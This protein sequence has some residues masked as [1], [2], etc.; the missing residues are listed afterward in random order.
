MERKLTAILC[1][2]VYGYSR[3]MG[4]DEEAT[5]RTLSSYRKIVDNFIERHHGRFV[6]SA[7]DSILAE[8]TS[9]V[10]AVN[11]AVNVQ[12]AIKAENSNLS[13][14]R[15]MEFRIGVNSGDVMVE[16]E[17]IYGDGVNVAARLENLAEPGGICISGT[18][19][20]QVRDR[21]DLG[22]EDCGQQSV[23]NI[24][25]PVHIWRVVSAGTPPPARLGLKYWRRGVVSL[26]G[27]AIAVGT[28]VLVQHLSLK[29]PHTSASIPPT[30]RPTLVLPAIPSIAV[31]PFTNLSGDPQQEY[32]SDGITNQL[33]EELSRLPG[34]FVIARNSSFAYKG[35]AI[36][37]RDIGRELGVK[38]VLEGTARKTADQVR[39]GVALVDTTSG[40]ELWTARYDQPSKDVFAVQDEIVRR[41]VTTLG[42]VVKADQL[43]VPHWWGKPT[44]N[45]EAFDDLLRAYQYMNRFT[46]D[47]NA[48]ARNWTEKAI[49]L[50]PKSADA[51]S[52]LAWIYF[53]D[54]GWQWTAD[55]QA[56]LRRSIELAQKALTLDDSHC[57]AL[58]LLANDYVFQGQFDQAVAAG[59]RAVSINPNCSIGYAF[60]AAALNAAGKPGEA[61]RAVEKAMRLDPAGYAFYAGEVGAADILMGRYQ[62]AVPS[63]QRTIAATPNAS[64]AHLELAVAYVELG[65]DRDARAEAAEVMRVSPNY[66]LPRQGTGSAVP[67]L[68]GT[69]RALQRRFDTDLRRAGLK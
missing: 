12:N 50:D 60:L 2:D 45:L 29:P 14:E 10:E 32:F 26:T 63:L 49:E 20:E 33:I 48:R 59:E 34:L 21:I 6:S 35:K 55:L 13:P 65:R 36:T 30:E 56:S 64:W 44:D 69:D 68:A 52:T 3:L 58:A 23:K 46:R 62:E 18:V 43:N 22:Y 4:A 54:A 39:I 15:R 31:V 42:L 41:V 16:G 7:G 8:F 53:F 1:A 5:L 19:Y 11:C 66:V 24:A 40:A 25:R 57:G 38:Y 51:Y 67:G 37:E 61:L 17:Q 27:L 28:F 9:V 47:D